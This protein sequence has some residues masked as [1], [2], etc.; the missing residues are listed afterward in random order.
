[1]TKFE[2]AIRKIGL[3]F[4]EAQFKAN[5]K[6][7]L[8]LALMCCFTAGT[9]PPEWVRRAWLKACEDAKKRKIKSWDEVLGPPVAKGTHGKTRE[10]HDGLRYRVVRRV[11]DSKKIVPKLF[12]EI[13][14][15]IKADGINVT[16]TIVKNI[17]YSP[18]GKGLRMFI[19]MTESLGFDSSFLAKK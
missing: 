9:M 7:A 13:A 10:L 8:P 2:E 6:E 12:E 16:T 18:E 19:E 17:Y 4:L 5:V 3:D 14:D 15:E 1:M 11:M